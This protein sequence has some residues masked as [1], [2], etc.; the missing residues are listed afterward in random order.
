MVCQ[1]NVDITLT[2]SRDGVNAMT[3]EIN[4]NSYIKRHDKYAS[5]LFEAR[6]ELSWKYKL[7]LSLG[8]ALL[9]ALAAQVRFMIPWT[10]VP[11]TLQVFT[12]LFAGVLLG[13]WYGTLSMG[14][15]A[16]M[17]AAGLPVFS[18]MS[19]GLIVLAGPTGGYIVGFMFAAIVIGDA[20]DSY[21]RIRK[22]PWLFLL[23]FAGVG[24]IYLCGAIQLSIFLGSDIGTAIALGVAPFIIL[25]LSKACGAAV[26]SRLI[27]PSTGRT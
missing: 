14:M 8:F 17:G 24:I 1:R 27:L 11:I 4:L 9:T 7:C 3:V 10:P 19:G 16:G 21:P 23:M 13:R 20:V 26:V 18:G 2:F 15:Y 22:V 25:D 5:R 6:N 12:V